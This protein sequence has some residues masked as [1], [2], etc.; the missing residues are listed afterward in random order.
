VLRALSLV[1]VLTVWEILG[2]RINPIFFST[3]SLVFDAAL[4]LLADG[5]L[6]EAMAVSLAVVMAGFALACAIGIPL[7]LAMGRSRT[8]EHLLDPF[9]NA[10]YVIPRIALIPLIIIWF[11]LGVGAQ[12]AVV[13][14]TTVFP[15]LLSTYTGAR[16]VSPQLV[17][18]VRVQGASELQMFRLVIVPASVPFIMSGLR[19]GV[20]QAIIGMVVAQMFL[21]MSGMGYML[22]NLGNRFATSH[23]LVVVLALSVL[24]LGLTELV[25]SAERRFSHWRS[26]LAQ[27]RDD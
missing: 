10:L 27:T 19:L 18:A 15:V 9:V 14:G 20:G 23:V 3:P 16:N 1:V 5:E 17:E 24:G 22:V 7:G 2:R 25:K 12:V 6:L 21:G 4:E 11:G 26:D 13:F 8:L